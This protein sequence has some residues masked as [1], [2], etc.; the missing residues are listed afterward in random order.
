MPRGT[1]VDKVRRFFY[2][3]PEIEDVFGAFAR[4]HWED[5]N[6]SENDDEEYSLEMT[7]V[8]EKYR[9][10]FERTFERFIE[11]NDSSVEE[12]YTLLRESTRSES[13]SHDAS[14][15]AEDAFFLQIFLATTEFDVFA[16]LMRDTAREERRRR[17]ARSRASKRTEEEDDEEASSKRHNDVTVDDLSDDGDE[18]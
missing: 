3:S 16:Q 6:V 17:R 10:L 9:D 15:H 8:Y 14:C 5:A 12:F 1:I 11:E 2:E 4:R 13:S 18:I 7:R